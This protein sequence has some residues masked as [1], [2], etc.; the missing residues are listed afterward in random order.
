MHSSGNRRFPLQLL[1]CICE[2]DISRR[3]VP[4]RAR[5]QPT[6]SRRAHAELKTSARARG[7]RGA[8]GRRATHPPAARSTHRRPPGGVA[9][10]W[11]VRVGVRVG[12]VQVVRFPCNTARRRQ[13]APPPSN[14]TEF[15]TT[16]TIPARERQR[17]P[18]P[19]TYYGYAE[20]HHTCAWKVASSLVFCRPLLFITSS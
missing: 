6:R 3:P 18:P 11:G 16:T 4:P 2:L 20:Y 17:A 19:T 10:G 15:T 13:L 8:R 14:T 7:G 9:R 12:L 1:E 5:A